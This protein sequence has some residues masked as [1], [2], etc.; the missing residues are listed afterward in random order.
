MHMGTEQSTPRV[1]APVGLRRGDHICAGRPGGI[2]HDGIYLG[3]GQVIH[4]ASTPGQGKRGARVQVSTLSEFASGQPV[5]VRPYADS[6]DPEVIIRR[7]MSRL[8]EGGYNLVFNNCQHFA[9]WCATGQHCSE[10]VNAVSARAASAL[11]P[12]IGIPASVVTVGSVGLVEGLS[13][14]GIMAGLACCGRTVGGGAADGLVV[15]G[16]LVGVATILAMSPQLRDDY[17]LPERERA[18]RTARRHGVTIGLAAGCVG[19]ILAVN[20]LGTPGLS[21]AGITSGLAALGAVFGGRMKT[22]TMCAVAIPALAVILCGY[23][24]SNLYLRH[25]EP[26]EQERNPLGS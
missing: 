16:S 21:G 7:A 4:M 1:Q 20:A 15:L 2:R 6:D 19:T 12:A 10:Q 9:R 22:G 26:E 18:A 25:S 8:G 3:N 14:P 24:A 11:V 17:V 5:T 23:V 13:G